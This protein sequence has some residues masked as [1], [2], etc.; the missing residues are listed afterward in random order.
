MSH[1]RRTLHAGRRATVAGMRVVREPALGGA[2]SIVLDDDL[3]IEANCAEVLGRLPDGAFDL[4]YI[5][6]PFNTGRRREHRRLRTVRD[7][8]GGDRT[9]FGGR[10]Y[11]SQLLSAIAYDDEFGD[12]L[13]FLEPRLRRARDLLAE[14]GTLYFHIDYREAHY[15]KLELDRIFGRECFLNEII[16]AYDYG[17]KP[18]RRTRPSGFWVGYPVRSRPLVGTIVCQITSVGILPRAAFSALTSPGAM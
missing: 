8:R 5:D 2:K 3:V 1:G 9:G 15:C 13:G 11:R 4:V 14:H 17:G 18:K 7:G 12:Y 16:W 6:P 10:R